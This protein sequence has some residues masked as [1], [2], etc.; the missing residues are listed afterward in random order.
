MWPSSPALPPPF[1]TT[2]FASL[3]ITAHASSQSQRGRREK[4]GEKRQEGV[5][6]IKKKKGTKER[7]EGQAASDVP[8]GGFIHALNLQANLSDI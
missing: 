8:I 1:S 5:K 4:R 2:T 6:A 3:E 7:P